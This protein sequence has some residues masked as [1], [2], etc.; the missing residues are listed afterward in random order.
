MFFLYR[1]SGIGPFGEH[2]LQQKMCGWFFRKRFNELFL[3]VDIPLL[4]VGTKMDAAK[5]KRGLPTHQKR[6]TAG[7]ENFV[8]V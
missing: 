1:G 4:V 6:F 5:E 3:Q 2:L 7:G 8:Q